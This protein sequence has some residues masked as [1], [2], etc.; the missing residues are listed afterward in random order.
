MATT[1]KDERRTTTTELLPEAQKTVVQADFTLNHYN[2]SGSICNWDI[3]D[4]TAA[5]PIQ[6]PFSK[7]FQLV[8]PI[9]TT[10]AAI[11]NNDQKT[12]G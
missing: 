12:E 4:A 7:R 2:V 5:A 1:G 11:K 8:R 3:D 9:A 10:S 6:P